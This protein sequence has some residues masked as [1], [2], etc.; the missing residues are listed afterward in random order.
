MPDEKTMITVEVA[1]ALPHR[2]WLKALE[3]EPG[4]TALEAVRRSGL[5][6]DLPDVALEESPMGI[7][8]HLLDNP[9]Q[10]VLKHGERVEVY[11]PLIA[12]PKEVRRR[13]VEE[14]RSRRAKEKGEKSGD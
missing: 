7:F 14:A 9:A 11:R 5:S 2:Q 6:E 1:Y 4:C 10:Y 3:V 8:S 12:D 13:R